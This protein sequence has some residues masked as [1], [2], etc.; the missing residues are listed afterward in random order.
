MDPT[1]LANLGE[2]FGSVA[3]IASLIY[4]AVQVRPN[5]RLLDVQNLQASAAFTSPTRLS[6]DLSLYPTRR[7]R[8][9]AA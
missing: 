9:A 4:L 2:F 7:R 6:D 3:V 5:S 8:G 1:Q